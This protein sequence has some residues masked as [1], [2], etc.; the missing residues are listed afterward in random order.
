MTMKTKIIV[1]CHKR[2]NLP[3]DETYIPIHVGKS[4]HPDIDLKI[5]VDN[6]GDNIS[7]KNESY[8]ELT[9]MYWAWKHITDA[10]VIGL[11]HY[12]RYFKFV[13]F[14]YFS[15]PTI[16]KSFSKLQMECQAIPENVLNM[17]S[18]GGV[19][20]AKAEKWSVPVYTNYC[21]W[22]FCDDMLT[23]YKIVKKTQPEKY[24]RAFK[25]VVFC[26][27]EFAP[28]N[29]F[30]MSRTEYDKYCSWLFLLL[31]QTEEEINI[32]QYNSMQRRLFG[33]LSE[34]LLDVYIVANN[35]K[36][37]AYPIVYFEENDNNISKWNG[38]YQNLR[39]HLLSAIRYVNFQI[40]LKFGHLRSA[41]IE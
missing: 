15:R 22:H 8:C 37:I 28:Y 1:C 36:R 16:S 3:Q 13:S 31:K 29:M 33:Y 21:E 32:S 40:A 6:E 12:R 41:K 23:L 10:D 39:Y 17:I 14:P 5:Q 9:G 24:V 7:I 26:S 20:T 27:N 2:C 18:K 34:R 30:I 35:L 25:K 4:L 38:F 11:C 19:V